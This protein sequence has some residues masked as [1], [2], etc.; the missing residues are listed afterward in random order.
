MDFCFPNIIDNTRGGLAKIVEFAKQN[1][2]WRTGTRCL[3]RQL[4]YLATYANR[5]GCTEDRKVQGQGTRCQLYSDFAPNSF[6]FVIERLKEGKW[7]HW[8]N[9]GLIYSGPSQPADGSFPALTV[10]VD[11]QT[12][13]GWSVHT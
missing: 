4:W 2:L 6:R 3:R 9:G 7:V 8:F 5:R 12:T 10:S 1:G 11:R 13:D